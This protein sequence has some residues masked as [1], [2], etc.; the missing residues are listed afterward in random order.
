MSLLAALPLRARLLA[1]FC[2]IAFAGVVAGA[3]AVYGLQRVDQEASTLYQKHMLGLSAIKEAEIHL[4]QVARYRAQYARAGSQEARSQYRT[5]FEQHL[6]EARKWLDQ[7]APTLVLPAN[8]A[9][10]AQ[11]NEALNAY[12]PVGRAF[13]AAMDTTE[14]VPL[15]PEIEQHNQAA[16][17]AFKQVTDLTEK[18]SA[19]KEEVGAQAASQVHETYKDVS[20]VVVVLA[21]L[22]VVSALALGRLM[23]SSVL[24]QIGGEPHHAVR[25]A[26]KIASGDLSTPLHLRAGDEHSILAAMS[27]MQTRL[28][29]VVGGIRGAAGNIATASSQI[30]AGNADLSHRTEEQAGNLQT[31][32]STM[33]QLSTAVQQ[34]ANHAAQAA[35]MAKEATQA[36]VTGGETVEKVV[37]TMSDISDAS[38]QIGDIIGVIDGLAFQTNILALNAAVEAARAGEQGRGFAV[39]AGEVRSLAHRSSEAA[40]EIKRL[41]TMSGERVQAGATQVQEAGMTIESMV[42]QVQQMAALIE[43]IS[44]ATREQTAGIAEVTSSV[45][46]LDDA[47]QQNAS[48]VEQSAAATDGLSRQAAGLLQSV[49]VFKLA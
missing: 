36:A 4:V 7:A 22:A 2:L 46:H 13:L 34:N 31:T 29:D 1:A 20:A 11:T 37:S 5:L 47:T 44:E 19:V 8:R 6:S 48:L 45:S 41:I 28:Q 49:S 9:L 33:V 12:L 39:V 15:A 42:Q 40:R 24:N 14:P 18:L 32:A 27:D 23:S 35:A 3:A 30:A 21:S 17:A 25:L 26:R 10:L 16:V 38:H 43:E